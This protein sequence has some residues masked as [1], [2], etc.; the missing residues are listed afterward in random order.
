MTRTTQILLLVLC[1]IA[2]LVLLGGVVVE[3]LQSKIS[4]RLERG[5]VLPPLELYSQ[6]LPLTPGRRFPQEQIEAEME[7]RG[8]QAGRDY[9]LENIEACADMTKLSFNE[10]A[11]RCLWVRDPNLVVTW[12]AEGWIVDL[13]KGNPL[14]PAAGAGLFP[15][16]IT[17]FYD[18]QPILQQNAPR[19]EIPLSCLQAVIAIEDKDFLEHSGVSATGT[20]RAV[21]RNLKARRFAEGG[22]TITQQLVKNFFLTSKKTLRRKIEEQMLSLLLESQMEKDEILE[23]YLN[24]IYMGQS[25]PYQ[26]RGFGSAAQVNFDKPISQLTLPECALLAATINSPGRFN[27]FEHPD[28]AKSRRDLVLRKMSEGGMISSTESEE[29]I[30]SPLPKVAPAQRRTHAP[31]FVMSALREFESWEIDSEDGA[32]LYTTLDPESQA[33]LLGAVAKVMPAVEKRVKKPSA[34]PLQVAAIAVDIQTAEVLALTGGRDYRSTQF[35]RAIDSRRQIGSI[36]KPFVFLPALRD[37]SPIAPVSDDPFE[38]KTGKQVWKPKNYE[39]KSYPGNVP[40]FFALAHSLNIPTARIGQQVG[41]ETVI[42]ALRNAGVTSKIPNLPS[43][44]LGALELSP[45]EVAQSYLTLA[46]MGSTERLH[47]LSRAEDIN[48]RV[49]FE[50][51]PSADEALDPV[52]TAILVG[53]MRQSMELGTGKVARLWGF[54]GAA[55]G[56]TG[57]TS[58]TKDAW[59]AGFTSRLMVV[60]W[61]G[62]DDNT[63]M[64]L[65]GAG[66]AL[67]VWVDI[68][69]G[70]QKPFQPTDF[71]YPPGVEKRAVQRDDLLRDFPNLPDL[72]ESIEL[73]FGAWAS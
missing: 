40:L 34:H 25:G 55:A 57:T 56:K 70:I 28:A 66:A 53:M 30:N 11:T 43:L 73:V 31:Y 48:G 22:S 26:V 44:T 37:S 13:W 21:I 59:F 17:Q 38:W 23:M 36:V 61:V 33:G 65:T 71:A 8:L 67:P 19:S 52:N 63:A 4:T 32:R 1:A 24:V 12:D 41:L 7:K 20:F 50:Y 60:V 16:L 27:P 69:K 46:R 54:D 68:I 14:A 42:D 29:A 58:D 9:Y 15:Q 45:M 47:L 2:G 39:G 49:L 64:G 72:P 51:Q 10:K 62:Y 5:W 18:G 35:N 3:S 6:G